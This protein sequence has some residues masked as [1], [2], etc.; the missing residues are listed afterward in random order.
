MKI[1]ALMLITHEQMDDSFL[2]K[3]DLACENGLQAIQLRKKEAEAKDLLE[4]AF[5]LR[6][7]TSRH[8]S[9]LTINERL[10][11]AL[12]VKADGVH[13][14]ENGLSPQV[15]KKLQ[16]SL[17]VGVSVHSILKAQKAEKEG[18]DYI[19][20]GPIFQTGQKSPQGVEE[21]N[22][23]SHAVSIPVLAV[24][25]ITPSSAKLCL[26]A[27]AYGIAAISAFFRTENIKETMHHFLHADEKTN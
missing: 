3:I 12:L 8:K 17:T 15:A 19:L 7:I 18:A 11:V 22:K 24:G 16:P 14:T 6:K 4:W 5:M 13:F 21:L 25:G 26:D 20:F 2:N 27:G 23:I 9:F 1:P 10:D